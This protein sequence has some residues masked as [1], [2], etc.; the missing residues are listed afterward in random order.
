MG[1]FRTLNTY[2]VHQLRGF[3]WN[4]ATNMLMQLTKNVTIEFQRSNFVPFIEILKNRN[5]V[6]SLDPGVDYRR[7]ALGG[8]E[9]VKET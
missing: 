5:V 8:S 3:L 9:K 7:K 4:Y 2:V 6:E 1:P